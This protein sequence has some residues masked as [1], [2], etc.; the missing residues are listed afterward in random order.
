MVVNHVYHAV[1]KNEDFEETPR[2]HYREQKIPPFSSNMYTVK[3][4]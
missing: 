3:A 1:M 4:V 2:V